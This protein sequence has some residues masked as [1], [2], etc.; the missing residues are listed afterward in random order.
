MSGPI[1]RLPACCRYHAMLANDPPK[2]LTPAPAK[3][4][5]EVEAKI[6]GRLGCPAVSASPSRST[7]RTKSCVSVCTA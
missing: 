4:I 1:L 7:F 5:F 6:N 2:K 3:V